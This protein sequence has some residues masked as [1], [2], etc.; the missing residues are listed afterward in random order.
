MS[1]LTQTLALLRS[2]SEGEFKDHPDRYV[3]DRHDHHWHRRIADYVADKDARRAGGKMAG[4]H[5]GLIADLPPGHPIAQLLP[6]ENHRLVGR[7]DLFALSA[8]V[9]PTYGKKTRTTMIL[10]HDYGY[11][12]MGEDYWTRGLVVKPNAALAAVFSPDVLGRSVRLPQ[13]GKDYVPDTADERR[14][15]PSSRGVLMLKPDGGVPGQR[16]PLYLPMLTPGPTPLGSLSQHPGPKDRDELRQYGGMWADLVDESV[17]RARPE[18]DRLV[19]DDDGEFWRLWLPRTVN[20]VPLHALPP[21]DFSVVAG[22]TGGVRTTHR[23]YAARDAHEAANRV[24]DAAVMRRRDGEFAT[25]LSRFTGDKPDFAAHEMQGL[26]D[27]IEE[28]GGHLHEAGIVPGAGE[29]VRAHRAELAQSARIDRSGLYQ[30]AEKGP[31]P[32]IAA[33]YANPKRFQQVLEDEIAEGQRLFKRHDQDWVMESAA[34][35]PERAAGIKDPIEMW[36]GTSPEVAQSIVDSGFLVPAKGVH[37]RAFG[38]GIYLSRHF[39]KSAQYPFR[40]GPAAML[41]VAMP[42]KGMVHLD[43]PEAVED[44]LYRLGKARGGKAYKDRLEGL[45]ELGK[46]RGYNN[47]AHD[48]A[49]R[50][51]KEVAHLLKAGIT[52]ISYPATYVK[53][54]DS[55][56]YTPSGV[57]RPFSHL[58][59]RT[60]GYPSQIAGGSQPGAVLPRPSKFLGQEA[61]WYGDPAELKIVAHLKGRKREFVE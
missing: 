26:L 36:H 61:V 23:A 24:L 54:P 43:S 20:G 37:G 21:G 41:R 4:R 12:E 47:I 51:D 31:H 17:W 58:A 15:G 49:P 29:E 2:Y 48:L 1:Q 50:S 16:V 39:E 8:D 13:H 14:G 45:A 40:Q 18:A 59:R 52:G 60:L 32:G 22:L 35:M 19:H 11:P 30:D 57:I 6:G 55:P 10:G 46:T 3:L 7:G 44:V 25:P 38:D 53:P 5:R 33:I 28:V 34:Y 27:R 9:Q 56:I 42:G